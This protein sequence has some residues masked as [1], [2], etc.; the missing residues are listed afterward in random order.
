MLSQV[1]ASSQRAN[2]SRPVAGSLFSKGLC[3]SSPTDACRTELSSVGALPPHLAALVL[4]R[5]R[6]LPALSHRAAAP[7]R[8][9]RAAGGG[10]RIPHRVD[11]RLGSLRGVDGCARRPSRPPASPDH[12]DGGHRR[13]RGALRRSAALAALGGARG[14]AWRALVRAAHRRELRSGAGRPAR[15]ACRGTRLSRSRDERRHR[16]C[17]SGGLRAARAGLGVAVRHARGCQPVRSRPGAR[18]ARR[19]ASQSLQTSRALGPARG[20]VACATALDRP[21]R[22]LFRLRRR[23]QLRR[24]V[25]GGSRH[26]AQGHLLHGVRARRDL[27]TPVSGTAGRPRGRA[28]SAPAHH[29]GDRGSRSRCCH[30]RPVR[31]A[32]PPPRFSSEQGSAR[33]IRPSQRWY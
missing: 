22:L 9:R 19:S 21:S 10:R 20:R 13:I 14:P 15:T 30:F 32:S 7:S 5:G 4:C 33:S 26:R 16:R 3:Y 25:R 8:A 2:D 12:V 29:P 23:D 1:P 17:A 18:A 31:R 6:G 27:A 11:R 28:P 24:S